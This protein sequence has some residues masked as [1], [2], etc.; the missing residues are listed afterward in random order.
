MA[1][2]LDWIIHRYL[3]GLLSEEEGRF[4]NER[5]KADPRARRRLAEMAF[6]TA[7]FS[8]LLGTGGAAR[9]REAPPAAPVR[10]W[11]WTGP[12][13]SIAAAAVILAA[14]GVAFLWRPSPPAA[15]AVP[16]PSAPGPGVKTSPPERVVRKDPSVEGR[17]DAEKEP[18][19]TSKPRSPERPV[20]QDPKAT[21]FQ[22]VRATVKGVIEAKGDN[23]VALRVRGVA[24]PSNERAQALV[25]ERIDVGAGRLQDGDGEEGQDPV[26]TAFLRKV[27]KGQD[28]QLDLR[29][30]RAGSF[31]IVTLTEEQ[32]DWA[33]RSEER[34]PE[35]K[36]EG[37]GGE[38]R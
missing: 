8:D 23:R 32:A 25:G 37:R 33:R 27:Q 16:A 11:T 26:H 5:I 36:E 19:R 34:K 15:P 10:W 21:R 18:K 24:S 4:L 7:Q 13:P 9:P 14:V 31:V 3:E 6:D 38:D 20:K 2:D 29:H 28:V 12:V 22:G 30:E 1:E 35:R 17:G